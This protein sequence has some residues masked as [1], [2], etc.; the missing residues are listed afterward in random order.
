M[1]RLLTVLTGMSLVFACCVVPS[2][3]TSSTPSYPSGTAFGY[4]AGYVPSSGGG[5][6]GTSNY[7]TAV[8]ASLKNGF[9]TVNRGF[10]DLQQKADSTDASVTIMKNFLV[11]SANYNSYS[12]FTGDG[13]VSSTGIPGTNVAGLLPAINGNLY[14]GFR[15]LSN[16]LGSL[17]TRLGTMDDHLTTLDKDLKSGFSTLNTKLDTKFGDLL[18]ALTSG[19]SS[20]WVVDDLVYG[21]FPMIHR[22]FSKFYDVLFDPLDE[23]LKDETE[24]QKQEVLDNFFGNDS[25]GVQSGQIGSLGDISSSAG[26]LLDSGGNIGNVFSEIG[27]SGSTVWSWFSSDN[28]MAINGPGYVPPDPIYPDPTPQPT[29]GPMPTPTPDPDPTPTPTPDPNPDPTPTPTPDPDP[30]STPT[31]MPDPDPDPTPTSTPDPTPTPTPDPDPTPTPT[32][33][34]EPTPEPTPIPT[35]EPI[36]DNPTYPFTAYVI[37]SSAKIYET[38]S[39]TKATYTA[40]YGREVTVIGASGSRFRVTLSSN[41]GYWYIDKSDLALTAPSASTPARAK[42]RGLQPVNPGLEVVDF[43]HLQ[44]EDLRRLIGW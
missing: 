35:P 15:T 34:P 4:Y 39:T 28:A 41:Y 10:Y 21:G 29:S 20:Y 18:Q 11:G 25:K 36:P 3:A 1:K 19:A 27:N 5:S 31:P 33:T 24:G 32:P 43:Y 37:V 6:S 16:E 44:L 22:W 12:T 40:S 2:F 13:S 26:G 8:T 9:T 38:A 7:Y 23:E 17:Y 42:A 14:H 30:D